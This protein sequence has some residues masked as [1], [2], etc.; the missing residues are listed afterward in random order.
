MKKIN[1]NRM[2]RIGETRLNNSGSKMTIIEYYNNIKVIIEF[3]NGYKTC[4]QYTNFLLGNIRNPYDRN[5]YG[6]G[7]L[8]EGKYTSTNMFYNIWNHMLSRCY[9]SISQVKQSSYIGC[10]VYKEWCCYQTFAEW[11]EK[12]YYQILNEKMNLDKDILIK[13]NKIY[14]PETC[15]FVPQRINLLF[16]KNNR[17]RGELPIGVSRKNRKKFIVLCNNG[18]KQLS[19]GIFD[20]EIEAF[21]AYKI[22]KEN[23]IKQVADEYKDKIPQKLYN[24][25]YNYEVEIT[26]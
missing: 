12:N 11:C 8:G 26:D 20:T 7:Y 14:S 9:S 15:I 1:K 6:I 13:G 2:N 3:E 22:F 25:L 23:L 5:V 4:V 16:T 24:A 10:S 19:L 17:M 18:I 21:N